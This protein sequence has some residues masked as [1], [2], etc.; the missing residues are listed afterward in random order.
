MSEVLRCRGCRRTFGVSWKGD[1]K[2]VFCSPACVL[3]GP[4]TG[5]E[6]RDDII[7]VMHNELGLSLLQVGIR[8]DLTR[9]R[10]GQIVKEQYVGRL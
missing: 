4:V 3:D 9:Q 5:F 1:D 10:V 6:E 7:R 2:N 8:M